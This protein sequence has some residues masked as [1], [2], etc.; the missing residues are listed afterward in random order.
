MSDEIVDPVEPV[1]EQEDVVV[2]K[3]DKGNSRVDL[4]ALQA[5]RGKRK[6][7]EARIKELEPIAARTADVEAKLAGAL[8]IV[9]AIMSSPKLKA[10]VARIGQGTRASNVNADQPDN[11][12][13]AAAF[14][15]D[16]G[17][18]LTDGMT[19]DV[20]RAQ[21]ILTRLDQR[22]GRQTDD[23]IRPLAGVTLSQK[24]EQHYRTALAETDA[25]GVPLATE[26]SIR[27]SWSMVPQHLMADAGVVT[28]VVNN[29][30]GIDRR[31]GRTPKEQ[32]EPLYLES[33]GGHG[34]RSPAISADERAFL[35]RHG[36][37]EKEYTESNKALEEGM[38]NRQGIQLGGRK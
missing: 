32:D 27:E 15:E 18:Y 26:E 9:E 25:H 16:S 23:R 21:R 31:K 14:A 3:D 24:A 12:P 36:I 20:A 10:E 33:A 5:E 30:I 4:G 19:L 37:S 8:P 17:Y 28:L 29:A 1:E 38:R 7:L 11:D 2:T 35:Q 6:A 34:R 13:E 22:H